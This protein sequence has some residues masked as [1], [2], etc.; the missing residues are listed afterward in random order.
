[1]KK[2]VLAF[3][4][5][6]AVLSL[7]F[8]PVKPTREINVLVDAGHGGKD[9][10]ATVGSLSEKDIT[11]QICTLLAQINDNPNLKLHFTRVSDQTLPLSDRSAL[12]Q[13][14]SPDAVI[15]L[16]VDM[17]PNAAVP[18]M[19]LFVPKKESAFYAE[20]MRLAGKFKAAFPANA[21][22]PVRTSEAPFYILNKS[23][24]PA[25]LIELGN[26]SLPADRLRL[27][28]PTQ[29]AEVATTLLRFLNTI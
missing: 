21:E 14:L 19:A 7:S 25:L 18:D 15:S 8:L 9:L 24:A 5:V 4:I 11:L 1:M 26:L 3:A 28:D 23:D 20:S 17:N 2:P 22:V 10:G 13:N 6:A 29:Q 16:H 27:T 12:A